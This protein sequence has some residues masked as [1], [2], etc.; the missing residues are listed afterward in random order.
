MTQN[1]RRYLTFVCNCSSLEELWAAYTQKMAEFGFDRLIYGYTR[2]KTSRSLGDPDDFVILTNHDKAYIDLFLGQ[3]KYSEAPML[4]WALEH[5]GA[6]SWGLLD[7]MAA[8]GE[9]SASAQKMRELSKK[10]GVKAGYTV[11]FNS[12]SPREKGAIGL[13]ARKGLTQVEV[14]A[15]WEAY[16]ADIAL[17]NNVVHLKVLTMPYAASSRALS[18]RQIEALQWVGDGKTAQDIA[19]LMGLKKAT[20]EKHLRQ[21]RER[22]CVETTAQAVFKAALQNQMFVFQGI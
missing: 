19:I 1:L 7:D 12:R 9:L 2:Y 4:R 15:L 21:A 11:S 22:L 20:V 18:A 13:A 16:G 3:G 5:V 17:M 8:A 10:I 14:D 6:R